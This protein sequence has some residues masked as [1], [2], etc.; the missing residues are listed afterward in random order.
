MK[1]IFL[2]LPVAMLLI[3]SCKYFKKAQPESFD[4]LVSDTVVD[5][6]IDSAAYYGDVTGMN[7]P[8]VQQP[9]VTAP[10]SKRTNAVGGTYYMIVGCFTVQQNADRYAEK[11]RGM[12][13]NPQIISGNDNFQMVA[14]KSYGNYRESVSEIEKFRNDVTPHAWVYLQR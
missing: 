6:V 4:T 3:T 11:L 13:Y 12:G 7:E 14:A 5:N 1:R 9:Q 2:I 8:I 10:E